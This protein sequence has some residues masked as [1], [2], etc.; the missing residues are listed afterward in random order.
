MICEKFGVGRSTV[1]DIKN[2]Q[3]KIIS[4]KKGMIDMGMSRGAKVMKLAVD[5]KLDQAVYTWFKQKRS[6]GV[7]VSGPM[8]C[9]KD[10]LLSKLLNGDDSTFIASEGWKWRYCRR[11][12]IHILTLHGEKLSA[13]Q[14][15]AD[16][17]KSSFSQFIKEKKLSI[18]QIFNC[19]ETRLYFRIS[20]YYLKK[21]WLPH[22]KSR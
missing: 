1:S 2:N 16:E 20:V 10:T 15:A 5:D 17:F 9:E 18:H 22:L 3:E 13:D 14:E 8:L 11:H 12:G 7:P 6:E 4:F 19:D 21:H